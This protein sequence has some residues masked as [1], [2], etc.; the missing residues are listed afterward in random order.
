MGGGNW[1]FRGTI[2][3]DKGDTGGPRVEGPAG[4]PGE[5]T[6]QQLNDCLAAVTGGS[7]A[8]TDAVALIDTS[9]ISDPVSLML[10]EKYNE[11]LLAQRR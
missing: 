9:G 4:Q 8:N 10:A 1:E 6:L 11:L 2:K 5:V 3:G 7:S